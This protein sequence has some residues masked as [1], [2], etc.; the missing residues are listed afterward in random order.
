MSS[1]TELIRKVR[2]LVGVELRKIE[3]CGNGGLY[4]Q[5]LNTVVKDLPLHKVNLKA[6]KS[7]EMITNYKILQSSLNKHLIPKVS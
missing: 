6:S 2:Q 7:W 3:D 1:K 5:L 4:C